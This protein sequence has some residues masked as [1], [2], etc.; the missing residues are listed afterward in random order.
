MKNQLLFLFLMLLTNVVFSQDSTLLNSVIHKLGLDK[1]KIQNEFIVSKVWPNN[2]KETIMVVPEI[3]N[4]EEDY[5]ELKTYFLIVNNE[6][7]VIVN[8]YLDQPN[9]S[10]DAI[11]LSHIEIDTAPYLVSE[12]NRA[13]GIRVHYH[14]MSQANPYGNS[15]ISLFVKSQGTLKEVLRS[16][17]ANNYRAEW[18][19]RCDGESVAHKKILIMTT[20]KTNG[21]YDIL[22]KNEIT[23]TESFE[24]A[25]GNC[26][27]T[28]KIRTQKTV[29]Q[30]NGEA[31]IEK[32]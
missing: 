8:K 16:Y 9:L 1:S 3:I 27:A 7:G 6:T 32:E 19:M 31:Y 17:E 23:D 26:N 15:T 4:E 21:Y 11:I 24:D 13:F 28:E 30:F 29:L 5:F 2:A 20:N 12:N 18:N 10:S 25:N 14:T 22:V